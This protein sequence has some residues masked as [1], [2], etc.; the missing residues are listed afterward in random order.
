MPATLFDKIWSEHAISS[1]DEGD[2][3]LIDRILLHERTG[4][5][6]LQSLAAANR[7]VFA[8]EQVFATIDHVVDTRPGRT[9]L[10]GTSTAAR[11]ID[12]TDV[13]YNGAEVFHL[14]SGISLSTNPAITFGFVPKAGGQLKIVARD[15]RHSVF[16]HA[17]DIPAPGS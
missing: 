4:G 9:A 1:S 8:P 12:A 16:T 5:I 10:T 6:A 13:T 7:R 11:F 17:F 3:V 2:L 15:N 14:A